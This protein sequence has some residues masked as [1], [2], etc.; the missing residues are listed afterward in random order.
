MRTVAQV[1]GVIVF[2]VLVALAVQDARLGKWPNTALM[3][4]WPREWLTFSRIPGAARPDPRAAG[5]RS[6]GLTVLF[7]HGYIS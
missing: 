3:G 5:R 2:L 7:R 6:R 4:C 1:G